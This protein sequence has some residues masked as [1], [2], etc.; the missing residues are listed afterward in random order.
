MSHVVGRED[1]LFIQTDD[2]V[3][4][5]AV[6]T[7]YLSMTFTAVALN[8]EQIDALARALSGPMRRPAIEP[9]YSGRVLPHFSKEAIERSKAL[10][11]NCLAPQQIHDLETKT[12]F[13]VDLKHSRYRINAHS[14]GNVTK[15]DEAGNLLAQYCAAPQGVPLYD[16][17]LAQKLMLEADE[18]GFLD[19]ANVMRSRL[20]ENLAFRYGIHQVQ[21]DVT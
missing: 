1:T 16:E 17:M 21:M 10:L 14:C 5:R 2:P 9:S 18:Q 11:Y 4:D 15:I 3:V 12:Y 7:P 13:I 20:D 6:W 8:Q 19:I